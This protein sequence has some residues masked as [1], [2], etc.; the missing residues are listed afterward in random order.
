[1]KTYILDLPKRLNRI[2]E[3]LDVKS[4][5]CNKP[6]IVFNDTGEKELFIFQENGDL[7]IS[8]NGVVTSA[9][10]QYISAN[11]TILIKGKE[12]SYMLHPSFYDNVLFV[13]SL[14]GKR[15][16]CMFL[17]DENNRDSF[18]PKSLGDLQSHL[19]GNFKIEQYDANNISEP[20]VPKDSPSIVYRNDSQGDSIFCPD[21]LYLIAS[22]ILTPFS[23]LL[24]DAFIFHGILAYISSKIGVGIYIVIGLMLWYVLAVILKLIDNKLALMKKSED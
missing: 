4:V 1:M 18:M 17:I 6:W 14:D 24:I 9:A 5:L 11:K 7:I 8:V 2:S 22:L 13:L 3:N 21:Y 19:L 23:V 10:W 15:E 20:K 16:S 12:Q